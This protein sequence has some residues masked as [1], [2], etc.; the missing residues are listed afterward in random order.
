MFED[1]LDA[2]KKLAEKLKDFRDKNII[3]LAIPRGGVVVGS[4]VA[5]SLNAPLD[6]IIA[7]KLGYTY[8]PELGIGAISENGAI[9]LDKENIEE[10]DVSDE[11]LERI[12]NKEEEELRRRIQIY[13]KGR[14][15]P[16]LKGKTVILVDDGLATGVS[17]KAAISTIKKEGAEKITLAIPVCSTQTAKEIREKVDSLICVLSTNHL[18]AVGEYYKNFEQVSDEKVLEIL[19]GFNAR[20]KK[21]S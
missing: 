11:E 15:L 9:F 16:K 19:S 14:S 4:Q 6:V 10:L 20:R 13:R 3:I 18:Q 1:R 21:S 5:Q 7:R 12:K 17:A 2:G 8:Q